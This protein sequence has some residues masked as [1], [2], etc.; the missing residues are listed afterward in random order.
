MRIFR[1]IFHHKKTRKQKTRKIGRKCF[2]EDI[3]LEVLNHNFLGSKIDME[4]CWQKYLNKFFLDRKLSEK[5]C[6]ICWIIFWAFVI[7]SVFWS[8]DFLIQQI[9]DCF[10]VGSTFPSWIVWMGE[11]SEFKILGKNYFWSF[12]LILKILK[13]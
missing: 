11:L 6:G 12:F 3:S 2:E 7:F 9:L 1:N 4:N 13:V 8:I 10:G 5:L